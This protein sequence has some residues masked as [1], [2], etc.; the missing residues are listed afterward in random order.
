MR[1]FFASFCFKIL[2][3]PQNP[4]I[5]KIK[6]K[7]LQVQ[8]SEMWMRS[9]RGNVFRV[10]RNDT[11]CE[12]ECISHCFNKFFNIPQF[13]LIYDGHTGDQ[14]LWRGK[15][16]KEIKAYFKH[17][18]TFIHIYFDG[19]KI[20]TNTLGSWGNQPMQSG[21]P[22][23][24]DATLKLIPNDLKHVIREDRVT[25]VAELVTDFNRILTTY[26][27][28]NFLALLDA[29]DVT[30]NPLL[31]TDEVLYSYIYD[32][33]ENEKNL[34][35]TP[36]VAIS[37]E[38][39]LEDL[40]SN[41]DKFEVDCK[42][43]EGVVLYV[44]NIPFAKIKSEDY[45][46]KVE[47]GDF[48]LNYGSKRDRCLIDRQYLKGNLDDLCIFNEVQVDYLKR[49]EKILNYWSEILRENRQELSEEFTDDSSESQQKK[50]YAKLVKSL[51]VHSFVHSI[52]FERKITDDPFD[53]LREILIDCGRV[54]KIHSNHG[55]LGDLN[56]Y[57]EKNKI[58]KEKELGESVKIETPF[59]SIEKSREREAVI[60][61]LDKTVW[62]CE[63]KQ[64]PG[65]WESLESLESIFFYENVISMVQ[66]YIRSNIRVFFVTGRKTILTIK[67]D[68]I[69]RIKLKSTD[70]TLI[71]CPFSYN[72]DIYRSDTASF[73]GK[74]FEMIARRYEHVIVFDDS[75]DIL[76]E[77]TKHYM[78]PV[79][80]NE[81]SFSP[82]DD[83]IVLKNK[84]ISISGITGSGK[85][86]VIAEL[87]KLLKDVGKTC[88]ILSMDEI[89]EQKDAQNFLMIALKK[90]KFLNKDYIIVD[91]CFCNTSMFK[92]VDRAGLAQISF[93]YVPVREVPG[94]NGKKKMSVDPYFY[95]WC[96]RN[97]VNR[98]N[99]PNL[100][101]ALDKA[102][103]VSERKM[104]GFLGLKDRSIELFPNI[105]SDIEKLYQVK[106]D[107][108]RFPNIKTCKM[109]EIERIAKLVDEFVPSPGAIAN[110]IFDR[111]EKNDERKEKV[112]IELPYYRALVFPGFDFGPYFSD[113]VETKIPTY[114]HL[115]LKFEGDTL[116][117]E[118]LGRSKLCEV[119][120]MYEN[121]KVGAFAI[122]E[123]ESLPENPHITLY[124]KKDYSNFESCRTFS[125]EDNFNKKI[126]L[127]LEGSEI[128]LPK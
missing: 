107:K 38:K 15:G 71:T 121:E 120:R 12:V 30:G 49:L 119:E 114:H 56:F 79:L 23:F 35:I 96:L 60:F 58:K 41:L 92:T 18:G 22:S 25:I 21:S 51:K 85:T 117:G 113:D 20:R 122:V 17:D 125:S 19:D 27:D 16:K 74:C 43:P 102:R 62:D 4:F 65:W 69:L 59:R 126:D 127:Q 36:N 86:S 44:E 32:I 48:D 67:I 91:A 9:G 124:T 47:E 54:D 105:L 64:I 128:L 112:E 103:L 53:F 99:H 108:L 7:D 104:M 66:T 6:Y 98:K 84:V 93:S 81:G 8:Y 31:N 68:A 88:T 10:N 95:C 76:K 24:S 89:R 29:L 73:K 11:H 70:Y 61:D 5:Q 87:G 100:Q 77:A 14:I 39:E 94:K 111:L 52:L 109:V 116:E 13:P 118:R 83:N 106:N 2:F 34:R 75:I 72:E 33:F 3:E 40:M 37:S 57:E 101:G 46:K 115:T 55:P 97:I 42:T 110:E 82:F 123:T 80:A 1:R 78:Y 90:A 50:K 28:G 26:K 63:C 45:L